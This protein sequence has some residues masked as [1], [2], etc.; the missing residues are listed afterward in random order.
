MMNLSKEDRECLKSLLLAVK[1]KQQIKDVL[2]SKYQVSVDDEFDTYPDI[3]RG[4]SVSNGV[5]GTKLQTCL[6]F[7][8]SVSV[9]IEPRE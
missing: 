7:S 9:S 4:L 5:N 3:I 6:Q 8:D 2:G 1:T